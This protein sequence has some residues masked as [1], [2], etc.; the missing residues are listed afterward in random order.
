MIT[1]LSV[2]SLLR[3]REWLRSIVMSTSVCVCVCVSIIIPASNETTQH[4]ELTNVQK[5]AA[6]NNLQLN[7]SKSTEVI[8]RNHR[9]RRHYA[10][11]AAEP[12]PLPGIARSSCLKMLGVS[13]ENNF[14]IAQ[15]VQRLVTASAQTVY[16]LRMLQTRGLDDD[17]LQHTYR[18][19]VVARLTY[20]A[21]AWRGLTIVTKAPDRKRID[22]V[23]DHARRHRHCPPDLPTF[24]ELCNIAG[25]ELF[26]RAMLLSN[27]VLHTLILPQSSV[28][29]SYN[30]RHG[31]H[32]LQLP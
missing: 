4:A 12:A 3:Q 27:H 15:H 23:L 21:S 2:D 17:A 19:T 18:A 5:W 28:S 26:G 7:C 16:A 9:R 24:D 32:S 1:S 25:D 22:S 13:I 31:A 6:R 20:A 8:F 11:D 29:Q 30:L 10:A 14:A